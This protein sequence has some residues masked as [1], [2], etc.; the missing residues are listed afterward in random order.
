[1]RKASGLPPPYRMYDLTAGARP[2]IPAPP[3]PACKSLP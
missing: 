3:V 1:M 2:A